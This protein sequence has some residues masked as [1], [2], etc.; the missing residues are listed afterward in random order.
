MFNPLDTTV[1]TLPP[2]FDDPNSS[3]NL[4]TRGSYA[5]GTSPRVDGHVRMAP[6][7]SEDFN[8]LKRTKINETSDVLL[9]VNFLNAF[10]RHVWNRPGD[11]GPYDSNALPGQSTGPNDTFGV[12]N[13][14]NYSTTGG[15]GYL[16]FPRR[17][18]LQL[19][20]EF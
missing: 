9:Q 11:L 3:Q 2:A 15:G 7:L 12:I 13:W 17:I 4:A 10:N 8:L 6:Y 18:Q 16:L 14:N 5:F 19:K 1:N 20:Y